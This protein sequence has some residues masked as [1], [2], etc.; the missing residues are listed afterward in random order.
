MS[1]TKNHWFGAPSKTGASAIAK[2]TDAKVTTEIAE[3]GRPVVVADT[4][5]LTV[6]E[7][8]VGRAAL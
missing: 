5:T 8:E 1:E 7:K 4:C 3:T 6:A 2:L